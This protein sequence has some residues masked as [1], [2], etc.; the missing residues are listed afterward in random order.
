MSLLKKLKDI[1]ITGLAL[2]LFVGAFSVAL[3]DGAK[4]TLACWKLK[5]EYNLA[6]R[7]YG[8]LDKD[9][10]ISSSEE[11]AF[12]GKLV[13][14]IRKKEPGCEDF[15][16]PYNGINAYNPDAKKLLIFVQKYAN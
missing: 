8:D 16:W 11:D 3:I 14:T 10:Q 2:L 6:M 15:S 4:D 5:K 13:E 12:K 7:K 1:D 9:G